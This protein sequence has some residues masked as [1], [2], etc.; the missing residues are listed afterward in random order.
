M[1]HL[2]GFFLVDFYRS[3]MRLHGELFIWG[4]L[5]TGIYLLGSSIDAS[6]SI[7]DRM[8]CGHWDRQGKDLV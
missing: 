2:G 4:V 3:S 8:F 1:G 7:V 6:F 5:A